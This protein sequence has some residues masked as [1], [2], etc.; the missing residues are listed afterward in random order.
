MN[1]R[2]DE[3]LNRRNSE[4]IKWNRYPAD[5]LPLW[6]ADADYACPPEIVNA[7]QE[8]VAHP[9]YG[10]GRD[11][12]GLLSAFT[13]F[14]DRKYGWKVDP[15]WVIVLPG[16]V[17]G[18]I[19]AARTLNEKGKTLVIQPPV[20]PPFF[21]VTDDTD[22]T[23]RYSNLIN[24][25]EGNYTVD[26][27]AFEKDIADNAAMFLLCSPHNPVGRVFTREELRRMAEICLKYNVPIC[28]DEIH[29]DLVYS[30][31]QHTP[32]A[33]ISPEIANNSITLMAPSKTFNVAGLECAMAIIPNEDLRKRFAASR[34]GIVSESNFLGVIAGIAG[35]SQGEEWLSEEI[36][37]LQGNRDYL[38]EFIRAHIPEIKV[39]KP[40]GTYLAWLDCSAL[41]LQP[42]P[43]DFFLENAKVGLS[44]GEYFGEPGKPFVRLNYACTRKTLVEALERMQRAVDRH[45]GRAN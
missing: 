4:C 42:S 17:T 40:Q 37:H 38:L 16:V 34:V 33:M 28:S 15:S 44:K 25:G 19:L 3:D 6:V 35:Y 1:Y 2:F 22:L 11:L 14:V 8:R 43:Y 27:A 36:K 31:Y 20:Y 26:F 12:K 45:I 5:V 29:S 32:L 10:Y 24:D 9:V 7:L 30:E 41:D 13:G 18:T 23:L 21:E 39:A